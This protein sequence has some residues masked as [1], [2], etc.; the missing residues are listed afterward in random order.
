MAYEHC[1][2]LGGKTKIPLDISPE[3]Q[4]HKNIQ[5]CIK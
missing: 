3:T 1:K 5:V 4:Q 2:N